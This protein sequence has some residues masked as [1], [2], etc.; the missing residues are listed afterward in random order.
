MKQFLNYCY[1]TLKKIQA[2]PTFIHDFRI[3]VRYASLYQ[4]KYQLSKESL[5][6]KILLINHQLEKAQTYNNPKKGYG[7]EK[8]KSLIRILKQYLERYEANETTETAFAIIK[9]HIDNKNAYKDSYIT[10]AYEELANTYTDKTCKVMGGV[11]YFDTDT[12]KNLNYEQLLA[13]FKSRHSCRSYS[14]EEITPSEIKKA[15]VSAQTAPSACNRQL[16]RIHTY[17]NPE[18]IKEII[19][20]QSS[21]IEWCLSANKLFIITTNLY[22]LRD[23]CERNQG[24][25]DAGLFAMN[26]VHALNSLG[27]DSCFKMANK[28]IKL[29]KATKRAA[30]I[31]GNEDINILII[32]G[33]QEKIASTKYAISQR[34]NTETIHTFH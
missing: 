2:I 6:G 4:S 27:I 20:A 31:P 14:K 29:E 30:N 3:H 33:K 16:P 13:F 1:R 34:V 5:I 15:I 26:F 24:M 11:A 25:F 19:Y 10:D 18:K 28:L 17:S 7:Q 12:S 22:L 23:H 32:A 21:D 9:S 8:V